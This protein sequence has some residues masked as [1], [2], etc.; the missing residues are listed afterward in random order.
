MWKWV[1][2]TFTATC[3]KHF[4]VLC[5]EWV[6]IVN[7]CLW[8]MKIFHRNCCHCSN[9]VW[10][11]FTHFWS[12]QKYKKNEKKNFMNKIEQQQIKK[13]PMQNSNFVSLILILN[14]LRF[15][16]ANTIH[17]NLLMKIICL[18]WRPND[19]LIR[20]LNVFFLHC[21]SLLFS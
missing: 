9:H 15:I 18:R 5:Y 21:F 7:T 12:L 10:E 6:W 8:Y 4:I 11:K 20:F 17:N 14:S 16:R 1:L 2:Y 3:A 13:Q 19:R